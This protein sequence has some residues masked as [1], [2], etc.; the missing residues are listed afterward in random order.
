M[1]NSLLVFSIT[2]LNLGFG[3]SGS[4]LHMYLVVLAAVTIAAW[5]A[6]SGYS[7]AIGICTF[8]S[9]DID[10]LFA[11]T[12]LIQL[13]KD[14]LMSLM[15]L[16][17]S[18]MIYSLGILLTMLKQFVLTRFEIYGINSYIQHAKQ[19]KDYI[20]GTVDDDGG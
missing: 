14:I 15:G 19:V 6:L 13:W 17:I 7:I 11:I 2:T 1:S 3:N 20:V 5:K 18:L 8:G 12:Y 4:D 16:N 9:V 10:S